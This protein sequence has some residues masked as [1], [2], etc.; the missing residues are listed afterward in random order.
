VD[1]EICKRLELYKISSFVILDGD[2]K[3]CKEFLNKLDQVEYVERHNYEDEKQKNS[4]ITKC[5]SGIYDFL[6]KDNNR[7]SGVMKSDITFD[8]MLYVDINGDKK[9]EAVIPV[10]DFINYERYYRTF[11]VLNE[12]CQ[13][14]ELYISSG[15][16]NENL[17]RLQD[18]TYLQATSPN[19]FYRR[20][21]EISDKANN[22]ICVISSNRGLLINELVPKF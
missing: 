16:D 9:A 21:F 19:H 14:K 2:Q 12:N 20:I 8:Q 13:M 4:L 7:L 18:K 6:H 10:F 17:I 5:D 15:N 1:L 22:L 3:Q 11:Y